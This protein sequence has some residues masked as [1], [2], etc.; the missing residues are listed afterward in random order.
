MIDLLREICKP[1]L[2]LDFTAC[3]VMESLSELGEIT[4]RYTKDWGWPITWCR[5]A[6]P[7][8]VIV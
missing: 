5:S 2:K 8:F 3:A 1:V 7:V 6:E 4:D